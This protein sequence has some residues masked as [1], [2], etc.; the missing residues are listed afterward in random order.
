MFM[1]VQYI[2]YGKAMWYSF[3]IKHAYK[4]VK[5]IHVYAYRVPACMVYDMSHTHTRQAI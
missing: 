3:P 5:S 4:H 2:K 1:Q